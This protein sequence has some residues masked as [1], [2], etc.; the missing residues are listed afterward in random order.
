MNV[1][2]EYE[3]DVRKTSELERKNV[4]SFESKT[5]NSQSAKALSQILTVTVETHIS[6]KI[7]FLLS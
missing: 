3:Q 4:L 7:E 2:P 5:I 1:L 6:I